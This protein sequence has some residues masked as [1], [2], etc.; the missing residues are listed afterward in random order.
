MPQGESLPEFKSQLVPEHIVVSLLLSA[1]VPVTHPASS[2]DSS[3][4]SFG[5]E[6]QPEERQGNGVLLI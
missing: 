1:L 5:E 6:R 2:E 4:S 3:Y